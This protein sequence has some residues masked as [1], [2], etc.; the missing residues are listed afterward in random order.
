MSLHFKDFLQ[1]LH[2]S[3][4]LNNISDDIIKKLSEPERVLDTEIEIE[5]DNGEKKKFHAYRVQYSSVRGPYKGGIRFHHEVDLDEVK[6][7]SA[8]MAIKCA[9]VNIPLGGGKGGVTINPKEYS[10]REIERVSRAWSRAMHDYIGPDKDIPAPDV[11]TNPQIMAYMMD[12]Y[13]KVSGNYSPASFTGKPLEIGGS[14]GRGTATAQ[15]G[16]HVLEE[17]IKMK[18]M[19]PRETRVA[20]Q[21]FGNAGAHAA[22]ILHGLGYKIVAISDSRGGL[23]SEQGLDPY[24]VHEAKNTKGSVTGVY[25]DGSVCDAAALNKS[26][27]KVIGPKDVLEVDCDVLIPAALGGV[28]T[29]ENAKNVKAKIILELA[30][31]PVTPEADKALHSMGVSIIPDVLANAGGVTVSYFEWVQGRSGFFWSETEVQ[32]KLKPIMINAFHAL[33]DYSHRHNVVYREAA[34]ALAVDKLAKA[35]AIRGGE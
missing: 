11:Y 17:Y 12:E 27:T 35:A 21:G 20:I 6:S 32:E 34:F 16:V 23:Y 19:N 4:K 15:G 22:T 10:D 5:L 26:N 25:C 7:L 29:E 24:Q 28:I 3:A 9:V 33:Q 1:L 14:E 30:N 8:L 31:G 2:S 18:E 13:E